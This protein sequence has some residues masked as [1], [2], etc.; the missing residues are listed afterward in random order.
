M[1]RITISVDENIDLF[2]RKFAS[3]KFKFKRGW[4]SEAVMEAMEMW[5]N[6]AK[7]ENKDLS[8]N[9]PQIAGVEIW[10]KVKEYQSIEANDI[11][12]TISAVTDYFTKDIVYAR[13][14]QAA[15]RAPWRL[16]AYAPAGSGRWP[17]VV[18]RLAAMASC[19]S[20]FRF[21]PGAPR[22]QDRARRMSS[23]EVSG[24]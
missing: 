5:I 12:D 8:E 20:S 9:L 2:F 15:D 3:Q 23:L 4:Y 18:A 13:S 21:T 14:L 17:I 22:S 10:E 7:L 1:K 24:E 16:N 11:Y 6:Q 19:P